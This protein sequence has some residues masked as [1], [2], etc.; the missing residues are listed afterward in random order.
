VKRFSE[1]AKWDDPW[2]RALPGVHKLVFLYVIDRCDNAGFLEYDADSISWHTKLEVK[3]IEGAI[4]GLE[5]GIKGASGWLWVRRF[6][7]HQKN[8]SINPENKAHTQIIA[9]LS[10]QTERF[11]SVPE[12]EEF[13]APYKGLLS[14]TGK[15]KGIKGK[16]DAREKGV[17]PTIEQSQEYAVSLGMPEDEGGRF[18]DHFS[19]NGWKIGGKGAMKD[20][21]SALRNWKRNFEER[22]ISA[23]NGNGKKDA[24]SPDVKPW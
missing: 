21:K 1:T 20:W 13:I 3:H 12:F 17:R 22:R 16:R 23:L 24:N 9:L 18:F 19:S 8:D 10:D 5:R 15:G 6:L 2:F 11:K 14:P 7:R 4:K